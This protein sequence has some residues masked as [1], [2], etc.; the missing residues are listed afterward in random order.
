MKSNPLLELERFGQSIWLDFIGRGF[1]ASGA[2]AR[3]IDNDGLSGVTS[4]PT[5]FEKAIDGSD[6]Y[7]AAIAALAAA[8]RSAGQIYEALTIEDIQ[9]AADLFLP[10]YRR[11]AGADGFVSLEVSPRLARNVA[12][13]IAEAR[14]FW[15]RVNRPNVM[16]KIPATEEGLPVIRELIAEGMNINVTLLFGL[17]RYRAVV[18]AYISGLEDRAD[19][20]LPLD[21][22]ASVASFFLSRIDVLLDPQLDDRVALGGADAAI[23]A[24]L[25]GEAAIAS[26]KIARQICLRLFDSPRF[27]R[28]AAMGARRQRLLWAST[29]T[30]NPH[31]ADVKYV[32]A[33]IGPETVNTLP[34]ETIDAY[35]DHGRPAPRLEAD[36][37]AAYAVVRKLHGLGVRLDKV[38]GELVEQGV[39]KFN[40]S[41]D[42]LLTTLER[43]RRDALAVP[44]ER[45]ED[46]G[47]AT[48]E[49]HRRA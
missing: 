6:D 16:I 22:I 27:A 29:S 10:T 13:A 48:V 19:R 38:A 21:R 43:K 18:D 30:K 1:V 2:L 42:K 26:A 45:W 32:E 49:N 3:L 7:D 15:G 39:E 11:T 36:A 23:A 17:A 9:K 4:N 35:R 31:Y 47:G 46:E 37:A 40:Q 24:E 34:I 25:R 14:G 28:L 12:G 41:F 8:G 33:L 5:I 20:G 44:D